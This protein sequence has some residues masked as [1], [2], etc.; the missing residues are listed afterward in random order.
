MNVNSLSPP[1]PRLYA[2]VRAGFVRQGIA[3]AIWCRQQNIYR[4]NAR[5]A[6]LGIWNGPKAEVLRQRLIEAAN[7]REDS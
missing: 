6:L 7:L 5:D 4:Q 3:L 2:E 1:S